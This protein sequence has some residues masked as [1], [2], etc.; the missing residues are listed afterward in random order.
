MHLITELF[1]TGVFFWARMRGIL[2]VLCKCFLNA[3]FGILYINRLK[4]TVHYAVAMTLI[5]HKYF[6]I[7]AECKEGNFRHKCMN[8]YSVESFCILQL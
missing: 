1:H 2:N 6:I 5:F 8:N 7:L 3:Y 4:E